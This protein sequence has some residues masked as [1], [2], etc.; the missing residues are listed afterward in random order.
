[1]VRPFPNPQSS[2][3]NH[4][5]PLESGD[6]L[7]R[8]EFERRYHAMLQL[9]KSSCSCSGFYNPYRDFSS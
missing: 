8:P 1:M 9:K 4:L 2:S 3:A 6:R 7:T 5:P